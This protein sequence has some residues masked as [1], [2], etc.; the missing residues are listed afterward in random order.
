MS[1]DLDEA[2]LPVGFAALVAFLIGQVGP[3]RGHVPGLADRAPLEREL[4]DS[5]GDPGGPGLASR[6][7]ASCFLPCGLGDL[8]NFGR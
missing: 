2:A 8:K 6:F 3:D 5:S 1:K 4:G 7:R